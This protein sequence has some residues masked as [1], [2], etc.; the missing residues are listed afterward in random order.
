M[1]RPLFFV[2]KHPS[3]HWG[4]ERLTCLAW[5]VFICISCQKWCVVWP[6]TGQMTF[7]SWMVMAEII[8]SIP[9]KNIVFV[10]VSPTSKE[11]IKFVYSVLK[12]LWAKIFNENWPYR[13]AKKRPKLVWILNWSPERRYIS[14]GTAKDHFWQTFCAKIG[15]T[16]NETVVQKILEV[17]LGKASH[18]QGSIAFQSTKNVA[19][20][21]NH[22]R[23]SKYQFYFKI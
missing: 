5:R 23:S 7:R 20:V 21:E 6:A 15:Q 10:C 3:E 22:V 16:K 13:V 17:R 14:S 18:H 9:T 12:W 19:I 11:Q 4:R 8:G 2:T 1:K